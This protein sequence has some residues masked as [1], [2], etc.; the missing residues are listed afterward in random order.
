MAC[1]RGGGGGDEGCACV[2][3]GMGSHDEV[4]RV[5]LGGGGRRIGRG[6]REKRQKRETIEEA[7]EAKE[8]T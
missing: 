2:V 4:K 5:G 3:F 6:R 7:P 8:A 1:W